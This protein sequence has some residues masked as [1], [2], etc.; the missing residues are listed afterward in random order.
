MWRDDSLASIKRAGFK[1][2]MRLQ[3]TT[4]EPEPLIGSLNFMKNCTL[5]PNGQFVQEKPM[6][7]LINGD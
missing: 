6:S 1:F 4:V 2:F 3:M 5:F 7:R